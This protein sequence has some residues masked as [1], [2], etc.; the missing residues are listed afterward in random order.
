MS[1]TGLLSVT[2]PDRDGHETEEAVRGGDG[3]EPG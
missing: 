3:H 1:V 2:F